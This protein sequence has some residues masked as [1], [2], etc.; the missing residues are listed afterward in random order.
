MIATHVHKKTGN[1]YQLLIITNKEAIKPGFA[2]TAV[3]L[4]ENGAIWS[5]TMEIFN[6]KFLEIGSDI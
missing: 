4:D 3:Y 5:M 2:E 1:K 6:N